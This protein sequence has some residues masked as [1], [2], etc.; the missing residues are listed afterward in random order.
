[1]KT[2]II[3]DQLELLVLVYQNMNLARLSAFILTRFFKILVLL[4]NEERNAGKCYHNDS[5]AAEQ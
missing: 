2:K 5:F 1:M 4:T 3:F